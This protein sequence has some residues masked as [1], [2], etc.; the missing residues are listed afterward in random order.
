[1][2]ERTI[3]P[4]L[5]HSLVVRDGL[6]YWKQ[7]P[8]FVTPRKRK[9][10]KRNKSKSARASEPGQRQLPLGPGVALSGIQR[11]ICEDTSR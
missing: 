5:D 4:G 11:G 10:E 6:F 1:M 9:S 8:G 7:T 3:I 2:D